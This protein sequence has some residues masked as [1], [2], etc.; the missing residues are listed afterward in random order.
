MGKH[1]TEKTVC[2]SVS[3]RPSRLAA[4]DEMAEAEGRSRSQQID[5]MARIYQGLDS[6]H[7]QAATLVG[8]SGKTI[9]Q[10]GTP[11]RFLGDDATE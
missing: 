5:W 2:V 7:R 11:I 10:T 9:F 4:I 8:T 6:K 3:F 1:E